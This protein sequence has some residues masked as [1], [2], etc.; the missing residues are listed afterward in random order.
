MYDNFWNVERLEHHSKKKKKK[1]LTDT[2][3]SVFVIKIQWNNKKK[4]K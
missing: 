1:L 2:H 4:N 3:Q